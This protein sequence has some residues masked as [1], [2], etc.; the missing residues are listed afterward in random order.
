MKAARVLA[1]TSIF[2][3]SCFALGGDA[4]SA[5]RK[6]DAELVKSLGYGGI[7]WG[8]EQQDGVVLLRVKVDLARIV[9]LTMRVNH[10]FTDF[11]ARYRVRS[12]AGGEGKNATSLVNGTRPSNADPRP[13]LVRLVVANYAAIV[14]EA[15]PNPALSAV[16]VDA[17]SLQGFGGNYQMRADI[18]DAT[19][20]ILS[21][22]RDDGEVFTFP[23]HGPSFAT[24]MTVSEE[25]TAD[26][27]R[28]I[29]VSCQGQNSC[30]PCGPL[31]FV[32]CGQF[33]PGCLSCPGCKFSCPPCIPPPPP[34]CN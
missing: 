30:P 1:C 18:A 29:T 9:G 7:E 11:E 21:L 23:Y 28:N 22:V 24:G 10:E 32:C 33:E 13:D 12:A 15:L 19:E 26:V 4:N 31:V 20:L 17:D 2:L 8:V 3:I 16:M 34:Q 27:C 6:R 14:D 5:L 25:F